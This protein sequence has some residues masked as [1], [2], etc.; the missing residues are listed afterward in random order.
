MA[1]RNAAPTAAAIR[2]S[3]ATRPLQVAVGRRRDGARAE[4][5]A[6]R[7]LVREAWPGRK[8]A[9]SG[10]LRCC[11]FV[12]LEIVLVMSLP[13]PPLAAVASKF[14]AST[15]V[16]EQ[17]LRTAVYDR[18]MMCI[19]VEPATKRESSRGSRRGPRGSK[20]GSVDPTEA[21]S[22]GAGA[23][24][25]SSGASPAGS[26]KFTIMKR[27]PAEGPSGAAG[28]GGGTGEGQ[29]SRGGRGKPRGAGAA[30]GGGGSGAPDG[31][32]MQTSRSEGGGGGGRGAGRGAGGAGGEGSRRGGGGRGRDRPPTSAVGGAQG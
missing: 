3:P 9:R 18:I 16:V 31:G 6:R 32:A 21:A 15:V 13:C 23:G 8:E 22:G 14:A 25:D 19:Q 10:K 26:Q 7:G 11:L 30:G 20:R 12:T 28:A 29:Q 24:G 2:A 5:A 4:A 27:S 17:R 1:A